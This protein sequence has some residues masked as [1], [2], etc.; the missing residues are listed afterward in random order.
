MKLWPLFLRELQSLWVTPLAW[1][2]L[3][4]FLFLQGGIFYTVT[5]HFSQMSDVAPDASPLAAYYGQSSLLLTFTLLLLCPALTM[6][7]LAEERK[8]GSIELLLSAPIGSSA[9]VLAKYL[10]TLATFCMIWLPT[11]LYPAMLREAMHVDWQVVAVSYA[12][13]AMVGASYLALGVLA[14]ALA[15]SQLV[16]LLLTLSIQFG[17]FVL[18]IGEYVFDPGF[19]RDLSAHL[20][21]TTLLDE[22]AV[23][24]VDSRRLVLHGSV[25]AW[26]L[27]VAIQLVESWREE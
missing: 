19:L 12:G 22:T 10:A 2:L 6:R 1:V 3:V 16:A 9:I 11:L 24:L 4:S 17:L 23:G 7:T 14:S 18:G 15:K 26:A 20:S 27:F 5:L 21:L 8:T 25:T 13:I